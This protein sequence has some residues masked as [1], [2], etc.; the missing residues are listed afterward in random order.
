[1]HHNRGHVK[2]SEMGVKEINSRKL[3]IIAECNFEE[4]LQNIAI[5]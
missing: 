3:Q 4:N 1:M 5:E 2:F